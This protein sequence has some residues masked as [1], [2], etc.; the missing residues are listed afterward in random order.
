MSIRFSEFPE[1]LAAIPATAVGNFES[2]RANLE[3]LIAKLDGVCRPEELAYVFQLLADVEG[4]A[5]NE[6]CGLLLQEKALTIDNSSPLM[7]L[8][9]AKSLL[10]GFDRPDLALARIQE[11]EILVSSPDWVQCEDDLPRQW[12]MREI[13]TVRK[14]AMQNKS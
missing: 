14:E 8:F 2:A 3:M 10:R 12:Y 13:A 7:L 9:C 1:Y 4:R 6:K 11:A 5:G